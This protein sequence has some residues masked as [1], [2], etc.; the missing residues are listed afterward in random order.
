MKK[1]HAQV[2]GANLSVN[3]TTPKASGND[4]AL[5]QLSFIDLT[6]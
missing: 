4:A 1:Q 6:F 5:P 2:S 3:R